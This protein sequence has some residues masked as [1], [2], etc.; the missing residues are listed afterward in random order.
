MNA[1]RVARTIIT[2]GASA[3]GVEALITLF[4]K[5]PVDLPAAVVVVLHRSPT[6]VSALGEVLG[7]RALIRVAEAV[8]GEAIESGRVY[9]APADA[10]LVI[11]P[12]RLRLH[13]GPKV[14]Y[15]RPA[16]DPLFT[17]AA[18]AYGPRVVGVLLSG[19]G[20]DGVSGLIAIKAAGG[21]SLVQHPGEATFP[22]MPIN[23]ITFDHVDAI[24]PLDLIGATLVT[25][26]AGGVVEE[27]PETE[28]RPSRVRQRP[29]VV[30]R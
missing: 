12:G 24:L 29:G 7:R 18:A 2:V 28:A 23:A 3:G 9:V 20:D 14:H 16:V 8:N 30:E 19:G 27:L 1:E 26:A 21:L 17:S 22:S 25:L 13:R 5:F 4:S 15:T 6:H 11:E 10:H